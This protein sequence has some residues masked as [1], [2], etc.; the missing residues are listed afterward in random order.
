MAAKDRFY[1]KCATLVADLLLF[2]Y[3]GHI[4]FSDNN[5]VVL[6]KLVVLPQG[7]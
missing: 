4:V 7:I 6:L 1:C 2:S 3:E 5:Q